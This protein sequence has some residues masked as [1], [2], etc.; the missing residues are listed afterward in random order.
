MDIV[1]VDHCHAELELLAAAAFFFKSLGIG[2]DIVGIKV[3]SRAVLEAVLAK[4]GVK[5]GEISEASGGDL[6]ATACVIIDKLDKI[7]PDATVELLMATPGPAL[8][9]GGPWPRLA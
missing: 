1:G 4:H 7:G 3:N 6:F 5:K 8:G 2:S 9:P